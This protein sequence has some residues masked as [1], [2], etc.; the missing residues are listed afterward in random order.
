ME[1]RITLIEGSW[2]YESSWEAHRELAKGLLSYIE[3]EMHKQGKTFADLTA[4][5]VFLGPG[6][7]TGLRIGVS[8]M[9]TLADALNLPIVGESTADW[10]QKAETR[11]AR[12]ENDRIVAPLYGSEAHITRPR[13]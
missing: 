9:N 12:G 11:L 7:F 4:L 3:Q 5:G 13:K 10:Q 2:R 1:C 6:S 8:V